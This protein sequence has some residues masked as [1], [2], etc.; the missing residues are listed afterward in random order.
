MGQ[1]NVRAK[2]GTLS[3]ES[4]RPMLVERADG[5]RSKRRVFGTGGIF[6]KKGSRFVYIS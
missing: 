3:V 4:E 2:N 5:P 6:E 1:T